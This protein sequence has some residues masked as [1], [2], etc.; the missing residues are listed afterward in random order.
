MLRFANLSL[1]GL[2][3]GL[4][5]ATVALAVVLIWRTTRVVN[6]AQGSMLMFTTFISWAVLQQVKSYWLALFVALACGFL[7]GALTER[8]IIRWVE[9]RPRYHAV[10]ITFGLVSILESIAGM[11]WGGTLK[12]Y[13]VPFSAQGYTLGGQRLLF[14]PSDAF[15]VVA[16][17]LTLAMLVLLFRR[18]DLGLSMRAAAY[19][20]EI[21]RLLGVR[22]NRMLTLGWALAAVVGSLAGVLVA[23][24]ISMGP[25]QFEPVLIYGFTA[26]VIG[27]LESPIGALIGGLLLGWVLSLITGYVG[28]AVGPLAA[29]SILIS[30]LAL[31][32]A[33]L[34]GIT[35]WRRV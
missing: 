20:P 14:S 30:V 22:V 16:V 17:C 18:T 33:G 10:I 21:A 34:L 13:P 23:P 26:A 2:T 9:D 32:P 27:G 6:F 31:R 3:D 19:R 24:S 35:S 15:T 28:A 1:A 7:I 4:I 11:I 5:F 8:F 25:S 12:S 29:F